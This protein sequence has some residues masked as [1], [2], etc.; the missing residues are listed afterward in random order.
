MYGV[1]VLIRSRSLTVRISSPTFYFL[2]L[3][4]RSRIKSSMVNNNKVE[5][6]S[7]F[8]ALFVPRIGGFQNQSRFQTMY[9]DWRIIINTYVC[10]TD[11]RP[12]CWRRRRLSRKC[13]SPTDVWICFL[14]FCNLWQ[15]LKFGSARPRI[16]SPGS[17]T[18]S[19]RLL[20][21]HISYMCFHHF[22]YVFVR[23][24]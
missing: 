1:F 4:D 8:P 6:L 14:A 24:T 13:Q 18:E 2:R 19:V 21:W 9:I 20:N 3:Q 5:I 7:K 16:G 12:N 22:S 23:I 17:V 15:R 10:Q 11:P